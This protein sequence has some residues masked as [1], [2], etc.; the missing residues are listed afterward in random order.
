MVDVFAGS[1]DALFTA[2]QQAL[3]HFQ[4]GA[5]SAGAHVGAW[6]SPLRGDKPIDKR[7]PSL[8]ELLSQVELARPED[9]KY[10]V[11]Q[12]HQAFLEWRQVPAPKRGEVVRL[13]GK[14]F[15]QYKQYLATIISMET[16]KII[17]EGLGEVQEMIDMADY[18]VGLSRSLGG[19]TL[20]S[21]RAQHRLYE[22]WH[23]LGITA[24]ITAFN[25]PM[26]VWAWNAMLALICGNTVVWK[27][28]LKAPL[29]ALAVHSVVKEVLRVS[30]YPNICSLVMCDDATAGTHLL[31][32]KRIPLVSATGS[33]KMGLAVQERVHKR[34]GKTLLEL[35]GNS[36]ITVMDDANLDLATRAIAFG[37]LGTTGQR[38]TTSRRVLA[39]EKIFNAL[40]GRL[41]AVYRQVRIGD[42]LRADVHM[43]P[44]VDQ[45]AVQQMQE[46]LAKIRDEGGIVLLGGDSMAGPKNS[47]YVYPALVQSTHKMPVVQEEIFAPI[48]HLISVSS[49]DE[50][51]QYNNDVPQGLSSSIFTERLRDAERFLS[52][53]GSDCGIANV[54]IGTSGAEIGGAFGGEKA[55]G[56]GRE[57]GSDAWK[58]YMRRQTCTINYGDA[59]PLAQ[60]IQFDLGGNSNSQK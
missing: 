26:A 5:L 33:T 2:R 17:A 42:P 24:V 9:V 54:N 19:Q 8:G 55:T 35:G 40:L 31:D 4:I 10:V 49:L 48:L 3:K 23:P 51:I 21:E 52:A 18:A 38:C 41:L 59:L 57:A 44:L 45:L 7:D 46:G 28:S 37:A 29:S 16:G 13:L 39:H 36:A 60:G 15:R 14:A 56:G 34:F 30:G 6:H 25:F 47:S 43:G 12:S 58:A 53:T 11:E 20:M 50:A 1:F 32:D 22:Q 27:P